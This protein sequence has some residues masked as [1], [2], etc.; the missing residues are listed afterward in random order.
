MIWLYGEKEGENGQ[1][2]MM[3]EGEGELY[4]Q[5]LIEKWYS[6]IDGMEL[7]VGGFRF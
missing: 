2:W 1:S 6:V 3:Y 7:R 4:G 5:G